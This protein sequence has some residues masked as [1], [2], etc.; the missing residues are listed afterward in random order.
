VTKYKRQTLA[1]ENY[2][3]NMPGNV[4]I[5]YQWGA[6]AQPLWQCKGNNYYIFWGR[7]CSLWYPA[8]NVHAPHRHL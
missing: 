2:T 3:P 7:V 6:F 1:E 4:R 8:C 5:M